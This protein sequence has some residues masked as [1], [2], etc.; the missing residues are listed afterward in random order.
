[1]ELVH[2]EDNADP[3][4]SPSTIV[5][6]ISDLC[7]MCSVKELHIVF[8]HLESTELRDRLLGIIQGKSGGQRSELILMAMTKK[9]LGRLSNTGNMSNTRLCGRV[10]QFLCFHLPLSHKGLV[11][12][13]GEINEFQPITIDEQEEYNTSESNP[14]EKESEILDHAFYQRFWSLQPAFRHPKQIVAEETKMKHMTDT[15]EEVLEVFSQHTMTEKKQNS[16][17]KQTETIPA[18]TL[19]VEAF[20]APQYLTSWKLMHLEFKDVQFRRQFLTQV[21]IVLN[22]MTNDPQFENLPGPLRDTVEGIKSKAMTLLPEEYQR[23]LKV[24]F[25]REMH[26]AQWKKGGCK[27]IIERSSQKLPAVDDQKIATAESMMLIGMGNEQLLDVW[28]RG[29]SKAETLLRDP[30]FMQKPSLEDHLDRYAEQQ[31]QSKE[32]EDNLSNNRIYVWRA[33]RLIAMNRGEQ[34]SL[35]TRTKVRLLVPKFQWTV[36][37]I[38]ML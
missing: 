25:E 20:F 14:M 28:D 21:L 36:I 34:M 17:D 10:S 27:E 15:V 19:A 32:S 2:E 11:N 23:Q 5:S 7:E 30:Y 13:S 16:Q 33:F 31:K 18:S 1:M 3:L 22:G 37:H 38:T 26:W 4:L 6:L 12:L 9:L 35:M 8:D 29:S 24:L